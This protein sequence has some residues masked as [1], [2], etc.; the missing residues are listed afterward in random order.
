MP[1][2]VPRHVWINC[3]TPTLQRTCGEQKT[4]P[5]SSSNMF[6]LVSSEGKIDEKQNAYNLQPSWAALKTLIDSYVVR[7]CSLAYATLRAPHIPLR[8][9][10]WR[11]SAYAPLT[12]PAFLYETLLAPAFRLTR[13]EWAPFMG[14][15]SPSWAHLRHIF[16][17]LKRGLSQVRSVGF[18]LRIAYARLTQISNNGSSCKILYIQVSI[19]WNYCF[20]FIAYAPD[21]AAQLVQFC[22]RNLTQLKVLLTQTLLMTSS[23]LNMM[24]EVLRVAQLKKKHFGR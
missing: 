23:I 13:L 3:K 17:F 21:Y 18:A 1:E 7:N 8:G 4:V 19:M 24:W 10:F 16:P 14:T 20:P 5:V 9:M 6:S 2:N 11:K 22:L 12:P 15:S